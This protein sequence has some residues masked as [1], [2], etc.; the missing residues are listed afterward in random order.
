M[1]FLKKLKRKL[2]GDS[3]DGGTVVAKPDPPIKEP[4]PIPMEK[5]SLD[6]TNPIPAPKPVVP[7][8]EDR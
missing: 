6:P 8:K 7:P 5:P 2:F 3:E 1:K 4:I